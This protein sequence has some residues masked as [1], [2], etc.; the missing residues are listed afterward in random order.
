V[1]HGYSPR[2]GPSLISPISGE[3][4]TALVRPIVNDWMRC[5][6]GR[7]QCG[8][9]VQSSR[10]LPDPGYISVRAGIFGALSDIEQGQAVSIFPVAVFKDWYGVQTSSPT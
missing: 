9:R 1:P 5:F 8:L 3:L 6:F 2:S 10:I 4:Q 7:R